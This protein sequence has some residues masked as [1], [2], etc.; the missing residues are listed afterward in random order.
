MTISRFIC[1]QKWIK[2]P[3]NEPEIQC[4]ARYNG[5]AAS[6]LQAGDARPDNSFR[7]QWMPPPDDRRSHGWNQRFWNMPTR[8]GASS[9]FIPHARR[10]QNSGLLSIRFGSLPYW[11]ALDSSGG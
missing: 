7:K 3:V 5:T 10:K 1:L 2:L 6:Q 11:P 9:F 4:A 8:D